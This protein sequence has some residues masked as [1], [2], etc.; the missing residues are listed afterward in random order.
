MFIK[1]ELQKQLSMS[2]VAALSLTNN[3]VGWSFYLMLNDKNV[4]GD[5]RSK[6]YLWNLGVM[7]QITLLN[8]VAITYV[9]NRLGWWQT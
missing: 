8:V 6:S 2:P 5:D 7:V 9:F 3:V 4:M 1:C